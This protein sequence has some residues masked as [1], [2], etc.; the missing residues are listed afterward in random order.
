V[1]PSRLVRSVGR[2]S[3]VWMPI[4]LA[5][6]IALGVIALI[7]LLSGSA[8]RLAGTNDVVPAARIGN[9]SHGGQICQRGETLPADT[10]AIRISLGAPAGRGGPQVGIVVGTATGSSL[11]QGRRAAGWAGSSVTVPVHRVT[12]ATGDTTACVLI[13]TGAPVVLAIGQPTPPLMPAMSGRVPVPGAMRLDYLRA[14]R[15]SWWSYAPAVAQ[16]IGFGRGT[17]GGTWVSFAIVLLVLAATAAA[18]REL[19]RSLR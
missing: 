14:G 18:M 1:A 17:L 4:A 13:G 2:D 5:A 3:A 6:S 16:H 8:P 10:A 11:T 19:F 9:R 15:E 12:R 7:V